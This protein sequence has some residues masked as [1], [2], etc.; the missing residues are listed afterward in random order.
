VRSFAAILLADEV[1]NA[2]GQEIQRLRPLSRAVA[3]VPAENLHLTLHFLGEQS[4]ERAADATAALAEAVAAIR[5]FSLTL[6]GVGA[7][8]GLERARILWTGV[9]GGA[10]E[11]RALQ[12]RVEDSLEVRGFAREAR[13]WHPHVTL[14]R[15]FD[16]RRWRQDAARDLR[17]VIAGIATRS[18][19]S[20]SVRSVALMQSQLGRD[21][22]RYRPVAEV[23][24]G[25]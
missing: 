20:F 22:A 19:G 14:G 1:R 12:A 15:V 5:P 3:W 13:L 9:S 7:F 4:E 24:L 2:L 21:G 10:L 17:P 8:P 11:A 6:H 16:E 25:G 23:P 18:F